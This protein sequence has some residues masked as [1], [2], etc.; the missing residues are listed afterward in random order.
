MTFNEFKCWFEGFLESENGKLPSKKQWGRIKEQ[1]DKVVEYPIQIPSVWTDTSVTN[2]Y[3]ET[4]TWT[5]N[6][7]DNVPYSLTV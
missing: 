6:L 3:W 5:V 2:P 1:M 4:T 7:P